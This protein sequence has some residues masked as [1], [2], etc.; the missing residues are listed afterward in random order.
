MFSWLLSKRNILENGLLRG[1]TDVHSHLL[2][3]V[4]DGV[5][6]EAAALSALAFLKKEVGVKKI[7]LTPHIM[8]DFPKNRPQRLKMR[9]DAFQE[10]VPEGIEIRL[11]AEYMLD[12]GFQGQINEGLLTMSGGHVLVETSYLSPPQGF[13]AMLYEISLEGYIPVLAH[14]ERYAYMTDAYRYQLKEKGYKFQMNLMSLCGTYGKGPLACATALLNQGFYDY[15]GSDFH[16]LSIYRHSL[17]H[18][19]LTQRQKKEIA[20]LLENN[21]TLW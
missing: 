11:A 9:F 13:T 7:F 8:T 6:A 17:E 18:L 16:D 10:K 3:G 21:R 5:A 2:P 15:L 1:M 12:A 14:P 4:D 20:T 19:Y